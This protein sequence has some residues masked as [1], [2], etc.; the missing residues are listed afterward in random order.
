[1]TDHAALNWVLTFHEPEEMLARW[2]SVIATYDFEVE[3][4]KGVDHSKADGLS[5]LRFKN[6]DCSSCDEF[7]SIDKKD[8]E[9]QYKPEKVTQ[10]NA[11]TGCPSITDAEPIN[12]MDAWGPDQLRRWQN[13]YPAICAMLQMQAFSQCRA[14]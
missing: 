8:D 9:C 6:L 14:K 1:M 7:S 3:H 10:V 12:W 4:R 13:E 5:I 2:L 11:L